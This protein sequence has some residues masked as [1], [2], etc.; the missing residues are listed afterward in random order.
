MLFQP[1]N[2]YPNKVTL[3]IN[4][5][6]KPT[7]PVKFTVNGDGIKYDDWRFYNANTRNLTSMYFGRWNNGYYVS[8]PI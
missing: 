5:A 1:T 4:E 3:S 2:V 8:I 7:I 6:G